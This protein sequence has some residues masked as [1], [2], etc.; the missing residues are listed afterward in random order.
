M[1]IDDDSL[2][3]VLMD[4]NDLLISTLLDTDK[5][6]RAEDSN[7]VTSNDNN[8]VNGSFDNDDDDD[9]ANGFSIETKRSTTPM[10]C[11]LICTEPVTG[12]LRT[13]TRRRR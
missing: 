5:R 3:K 13:L 4:A 11:E 10:S 8:L 2:L 6:A 9:D 1:V 7:K 12:T